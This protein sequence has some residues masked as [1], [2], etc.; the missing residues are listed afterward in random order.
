MKKLTVL[1]A[2]VCG[3]WSVDLAAQTKNE[4]ADKKQTVLVQDSAFVAMMNAVYADFRDALQARLSSAQWKQ[5]LGELN[6][7]MFDKTSQ[8]LNGILVAA[9]EAWNKRK[10][11]EANKKQNSSTGQ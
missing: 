2:L 4:T 9:I 1:I 3:L 10:Q 11:A 8:D 6:Q 7:T 5:V